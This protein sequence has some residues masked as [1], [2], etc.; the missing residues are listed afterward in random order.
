MSSLFSRLGRRYFPSGVLMGVLFWVTSLAQAGSV[1]ITSSQ[2]WTVPAG[3]TSITVEAWGGGG[4]GGGATAN[5]AK[6]GGGAGG[7]Y[8][9][10]L[11]NVTPLSNYAVVVGAGGTGSTGN[12]TAGGDSIFGVNDVVAKGGAGGTGAANGVAGAGSSTGGVG[13]VVYAG[14]NGS[15]GAVGGSCNNGGAGGGGAGST[16]AGGNA[17]GNTA[18]TGSAQGGGNGGAGINSSGNGN[19]G[20][21]YG[22][23]GGGACAE[24]GTD[25][26]GGNG[27]PGRL[28]ITWADPPSATTNAATLL[29]PVGATLNGSVNAN[30]TSTAVSFEYG[31]TTAYGSVAAATPSPVGGSAVTAVSAAVTGLTCATPYHF[32]VKA[33]SAV[34]TSY[35]SDLTFTP[36]CPAVD[37][38]NRASANPTTANA[39]VSWA[40]TFNVSVT[41]VDVTDFALAQS[42]GATG[43]SITSV[44]GS[45]TSWT[46][47]ANTGT[48]NSGTLGL[49]LFDNDTIVYGTLPLGGAGSNNGNF[50][51]QTYTLMP[52]AVTLTKI[53]SSAAAVIGDVVTFTVGAE[54]PYGVALSDVVV[55][56]TLPVGMA[57]AV[58]V[59][60]LGS[61]TVSGQTL[62]W[63]IPILPAGV[64]AQM[65]LA[66][67]LSQTGFLTN[68]VT[69]PG[70][71]AASASVRVLSSA[72]THFRLDEPAGSWTGAAG[73]VIDSGGTALHGRRL[74]TTTPTTTNAVAPNPTIASTNASVVGGFCNAGTFDGKAVVEVADSPNFDYTTQLSATAWVYPTAYPSELSSIL[75][76]DTN[77]EFHLN[78]SGKLFWWW[79]SASFTSATTVPLNQWSHIA[80]TFNSTA[81]ARRQRIYINGV[82]DANTN[83]WQGTLAA[84][85]CNFYIGGD[86]AT[87]SCALIS[88]RNFRGM[89]DEVKLYAYEL[90]G[91]EV[92][93]DMTLGRQCTGSFDHIR[94]EHDGVASVCSPEQVVVKAC[95]D[96][97]CSML[98]PGTV[99]VR[100]TPTGWTGGD[101]FT[102]SG[103]VTSRKLGYSSS[104]DVTLGV[105][106]T[107]PASVNAGR[108]FN[109]T[110]ETCTLNFAATSCAFDAVE[111]G[112]LPQTPIYTKLAGEAFSLDVLALSNTT[113]INPIYTGGPIAVDLVDAS[114]AAC[115]TGTGLNTATNISF[116]SGNN[117]RKPISFTYANAAPNVKVRMRI[118]ASAPACSSDNFAIRPKQFT[119][120]SSMNNTALTGTPK[121]AAGSAFDLTATSEVSAGYTG[122]PVLHAA[123]VN[124]HNG[125][126]ITASLTGAFAAGD[127]TKATGNTFK[128]QDVGSIQLE[129]DA[130][131]D[132]AFTTVDQ[133]NDCVVNSTSNAL[134]GGKYGCNI[135]SVATGN[136]GRWHPSHFSF[137]GKLTPGCVAGG[138]TY[139]GDD[140]LGV[141]LAVKAHAQGAGVASASDPVTRH[142][143]SGTG[144]LPVLA[145]VTIKGDNNGTDV[146]LSKL[147]TPDF[148]T[149]QQWVKGVLKINDTPSAVDTYT[150]EAYSFKR[151][152]VPASDSDYYDSFRLKVSIS[153]LD[154]GAS[155]IASTENNVTKIRYGRLRLSNVFGSKLSLLEMPA[156][157]LYWSGKSWLLNDLDSCTS[158]P[159]SA[160]Y[161]SD[162]GIATA[163]NEAIT[164]V[165]GKA[166]IKLTPTTWGSV[167][168]GFNLSNCN[169]ALGGGTGAA[170]DWLS[171]GNAGKTCP[172]A[173]ATFGIFEAERRKAVHVRE[174]F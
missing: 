56:D 122:T 110:T 24:S 145:D 3:V 40:V 75:S 57:A 54:N 152:T 10:K 61:V 21:N 85:N 154:G 71:T 60:S 63:T 6:G 117:G 83:N 45:G 39:T 22:G 149:T 130:V 20:S 68:T 65:T 163:A 116:V 150:N 170:M 84:N 106:S 123:K 120:G 38:I 88:G 73:E 67:S 58:Y 172:K 53:A 169:P 16:A 30:G 99:T 76:N 174:L 134:V 86:V 77:Y 4:A 23:G 2:S 127:G 162:T 33:V 36:P 159:Y 164:L 62:T 79:G 28:V 5:P 151:D 72:V 161:V 135:G 155:L 101:T 108:C 119:V 34:G 32:R 49:T 142:Y 165:G 137:T 146:P 97:N 64:T 126:D 94:I 98:Y 89:I 82:L 129:T 69:S 17:S 160:I 37:S 113:T 42:G 25:R 111:T 46:V 12:G 41:G 11:I 166:K 148:P 1:T 96:A 7:Q 59:T 55:T 157:A 31:L 124:D 103:G 102:F 48:A 156:Q 138:F 171:G 143:F 9:R 13:D 50:T 131:V 35:G 114:T 147:K 115:P 91:A 139:M 104:G 80:I 153:D 47:T 70:A 92:T 81:G 90:D 140:R 8:A 118:G 128:Y 51:G 29:T 66:V 74:T 78:P 132:S 136:F 93:A 27:A 95:M 44:S 19:G 133:P 173:K 144:G 100:L 14:G 121:A 18:G 167:D 109:G 125:A 141:E 43:A 15:S 105:A 107:T 87:G 168:V 158:I 52:P 26:S 112:K